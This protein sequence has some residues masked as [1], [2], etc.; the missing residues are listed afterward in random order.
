MPIYSNANLK[1]NL[2]QVLKSQVAVLKLKPKLQIVLVGQHLPSI[3]YSKIK[4]K[5]GT[6]LGLEVILH[7]FDKN[8][9]QTKILDQINQ[10]PGSGLIYQLP[11]PP[12]LTGIIHDTDWDNFLDVDFLQDHKDKLF[13]KD[14]LPPTIQ[15]ID[16]VWKDINQTLSLKDTQTPIFFANRIDLQGVTVGVIG[17]GRLVGSFLLD[18]LRQRDATI[19]SLNQYSNYPSELTKQCHVLIAASGRGKLVDFNWINFNTKLVIDAGTS[20]ADGFLEGDVDPD[21]LKTWPDLNLVTSP[22]GIGP[23][24][25]LC[26][27]WNLI[28]MSTK[29]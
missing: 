20:E 24:T 11:L 23:I 19:I 13:K 8:T 14:L 29:A 7:V 17:Q 27:F 1:E 26:L 9:I 22:G 6:E 25:V 15:A 2:K 28:R 16:L 5:I 3:K 18:Y 4:Q 10:N 21:V 12:Q